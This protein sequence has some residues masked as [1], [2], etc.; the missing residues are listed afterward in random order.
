M[1]V[2][3]D[4]SA[5]GKSRMREN[6]R[7]PDRE[8]VFC[9]L[10]C[11]YGDPHDS[12]D[13]RLPQHTELSTCA[14]YQ[15]FRFHS[16]KYINTADPFSALCRV[17]GCQGGNISGLLTLAGKRGTGKD[18]YASAPVKGPTLRGESPRQVMFTGL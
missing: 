4:R 7:Q 12:S 15:H 13:G 1:D 14:A 3:S 2:K 8:S 17:L 18:A 6:C 10:P 11:S 16:L 9:P 5:T